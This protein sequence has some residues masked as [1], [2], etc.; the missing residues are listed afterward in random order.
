MPE[1]YDYVIT[2]PP[3][4]DVL[5]HHGVKGQKWGIRKQRPV[6]G[7]ARRRVNTGVASAKSRLSKYTKNSKKRKGYSSKDYKKYRKRGM[8]HNQAIEAAK[9]DRKK[10]IAAVAIGAAALTIGVL[11]ARKHNIKIQE[12]KRLANRT[13]DTNALEKQLKERAK[14]EASAWKEYKFD[15]ADH[16]AR[17]KRGALEQKWTEAV[18]K[19][20]GD[21][22][23]VDPSKIKVSG[24][25]VKKYAHKVTEMTKQASERAEARKLKNRVKSGAKRWWNGA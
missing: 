10:K 14:K 22:T 11:A 24:N 5:E 23:K 25:E 15:N 20:G 13:G 9:R 6:L 7:L 2:K 4:D 19:A 12:A 16:Y 3:L 21:Q 18:K 8:N 17:A 1:E